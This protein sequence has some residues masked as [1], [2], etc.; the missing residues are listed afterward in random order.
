MP[1]FSCCICQHNCPSSGHI[2]SLN[3]PSRLWILERFVG[4]KFWL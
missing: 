4:G 1:L 3:W 2:Y